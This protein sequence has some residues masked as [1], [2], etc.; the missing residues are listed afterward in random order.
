M[1]GIHLFDFSDLR[2]PRNQQIRAW[3]AV[4]A[5]VLSMVFV[6][7]AT[8][9][10][11]SEKAVIGATRTAILV[12][13]AHSLGYFDDLPVA[14]E[15]YQ[16]SPQAIQDVAS[17][18]IDIA[19]ASD[20]AFISRYLENQQLRII[21]TISASRTAKLLSNRSRVGNDPKDLRGKR[22][23]ITKKTIG[24]YFLWE[25]LLLHGLDMSDV[26]LV[27]A[28][29]LAIIEG[30]KIGDLDAALTWEP[31]ATRAADA[32]GD[33]AR[34]YP[35]QV[36]QYFYFTLLSNEK[37][38]AENHNLAVNIIAALLKAEKFAREAP[39][40]AQARIS[41]TF[42]MSADAIDKL[43]REH[44]LSIVLPQDLINVLE[45]AARWRIEEGLSPAITKVPNMLNSIAA[46]PLL[47]AD[48]TAVQMIR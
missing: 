33:Q 22:I 47:V 4:V 42:D 9:A 40:E 29:P 30:L 34:L 45:G 39:K 43:W 18:K 26:T 6:T 7:S 37:W 35:D 12:W 5:V 32:L 36:G 24:Q 25:Y 19:T 1:H 46:E 11:D 28:K 41:E 15:L 10:Q 16:S 23:G 13:L 48:S 44:T 31:Y 38:L 20:F 3:I 21:S 8:K 17:G 14:V 27:D 2:R